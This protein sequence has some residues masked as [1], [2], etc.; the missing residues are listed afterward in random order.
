MSR[1]I[2]RKP[3]AGKAPVV[4]P[5]VIARGEPICVPPVVKPSMTPEQHEQARAYAADRPLHRPARSTS[6]EPPIR[7][8]ERLAEVRAR[9]FG[10]EGKA[11]VSSFL[12]DFGQVLKAERERRG[13]SLSDVSERCG[14][15]KGAISRLENGLNANPTVDTIRRCAQAL[16][17]AVTLTLS[18]EED[19]PAPASSAESASAQEKI[20]SS[21]RSIDPRDWSVLFA[22]SMLFMWMMEALVESRAG[23]E[24]ID[25]KV[26]ADLRSDFANLFTSYSNWMAKN[27]QRL[28]HS[29]REELLRFFLP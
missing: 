1:P 19:A 21:R 4:T 29:P 17:K 25:V 28:G 13:L 8:P 20:L 27:A 14:V 24:P 26:P 2:H 11:P 22:K 16:G 3:F 15:E 12:L 6:V 9:L 18:G 7:D 23:D 5:P 10:E